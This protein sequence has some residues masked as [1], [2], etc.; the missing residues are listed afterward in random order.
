MPPNEKSNM[1]ENRL[2]MYIDMSSSPVYLYYDNIP[3]AYS[4]PTYL[5]ITIPCLIVGIPFS[6]RRLYLDGLVYE[7]GNQS[8]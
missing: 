5:F 3:H 4:M 1:A 7:N 8:K 2:S 6:S